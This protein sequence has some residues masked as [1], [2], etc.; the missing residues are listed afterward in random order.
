[1]KKLCLLLLL[2]LSHFLL[3]PLETTH[4]K[5]KQEPVPDTVADSHSKYTV[6]FQTN[7]GRYCTAILISST[8]ALT[9]RHCVGREPAERVGTIYP[10]QNGDKRPFGYMNI[11]TYT[12][13][14]NPKYDIAIIKGTERDQD[15]FYKYYIKKFT[16][17]VRGYTDDELSGFVGDEVYS[18]GYPNRKP[19]PIKVQY[20]SD[21]NIYKHL[22]SPKPY[23][24]TDMPGYDGQSG[25]GVFKKDGSFIGIIITR[26]KDNKA[27]TLPFTE[28][29]ANWINKNAK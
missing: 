2:F 28:D 27:N 15:R 3:M 8:A 1:M 12:P 5:G 6:Y 25:S 14:P 9:A 20:R 4:A 19:A 22:K 16:T 26:T 21:G 18:Y 10:G 24:L 29:I 7:S 11:S 23:L 13:H 17:T